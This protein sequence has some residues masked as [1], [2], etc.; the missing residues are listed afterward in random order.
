LKNASDAFAIQIKPMGSRLPRRVAFFLCHLLFVPL[1]LP[2]STS[3]QSSTLTPISA[4]QGRESSSPLIDREVVTWGVVTGLTEDGFYLQDPQGD[5]DP[6]TSDALYA[7]TYNAPTVTVGACLQVAG[8]VAEYYGKTEL[9]WLSQII[10][11]DACQ[12]ATVTPVRLPLLRPGDNPLTVLEP[13]E[14]MMVQLP[15]LWGTVQGPTKRFTGGEQE[16]ALLPNAWQRYFGPV[17]LFHD[18]GAVTALLYL[19]NGLGALL[20]AARWGDS[21]ATSADGLVGVLDYNFGKYQLLPL[22]GQT[23]R[24]IENK[25]V[26]TPLPPVRADE[27]G[28]CSYNLHGLGRGTAQFP[29][30]TEYAIALQ[31]RA[32]VIANQLQGCTVL[33]LQEVGQP[34]DAEALADV[35]ATKYGLTYTPLAIAGAASYNPEFP[36]TNSILVDATRVTVAL[37]DAVAG[38]AAQDF[39]VTPSG[40]C[41]L[42][43]HEV[44]DRPPL[45]AHLLIDGPPAA[46]WAE[47]QRVWVINNH[48]KSKAGD[49]TA[50]ARWRAVQA[51]TVAERVQALLAVDAE[52]Q[53][54]VLGDLNDFYGGAAVEI[55]QATTALFQPYDWLPPLQRYTY[56]FNGT[57]QTLDHA[58][59]TPNLAAQLALVQ[60]LHIHAD[61]PTGGAPLAHSDH[62]PVV[63]RVR[64]TGTASLGGT[65][66]W[67]E[68]AVR[69]TNSEG[70]LLAQSVTDAQGEFR[71]WGLPP[72]EVTLEVSAPAWILLGKPSEHYTQSVQIGVGMNTPVLPQPRHVTA[73]SGAWLALHTPWLAQELLP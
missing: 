29:N 45:M 38:C 10:P 28:V 31:Q 39:G 48:W 69:A 55:L 52:A 22:P 1:L 6:L 63:L 67:A 54:V 44:F 49:E 34:A 57:A 36:L 53:I 64:P 17:H 56:I 60:I 68:I 61:T 43:E 3:A 70:D 46:P 65:L 71:L 59:V 72:G 12:G 14:G 62:D 47:P 18:S 33:A 27:Y 41:P 58:L 51:A 40:A 15:P 32:E 35:L 4:I 5:G 20:P 50:N 66:Q 11:S 37:L 42:G 30:D 19:N 16:I 23:F 73:M 25:E 9:N 2:I 24:H 7:F 8:E 26:A 13:F 21:L